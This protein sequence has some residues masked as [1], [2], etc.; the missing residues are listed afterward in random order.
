M[1]N[2]CGCRP[3]L[4]RPRAA[5]ST[6]LPAWTSR[7]ALKPKLCWVAPYGT[8][9]RARHVARPAHQL[10]QQ[11]QF[12]SFA[13]GGAAGRRRQEAGQNEMPTHNS[14]SSA[15]HQP[16]SPPAPTSQRLPARSP[17]PQPP[18]TQNIES[19]GFVPRGRFSG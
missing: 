8:N 12:Q 10:Q 13:S 5:T 11:S 19:S 14:A 4:L 16:P 7:R 2:V 1:K 6:P 17:A 15:G 3:A 9:P 18:H